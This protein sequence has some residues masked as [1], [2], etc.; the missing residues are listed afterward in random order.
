MG[1]LNK[2]KKKLCID[3][4]FLEKK[5][6]KKIS[7]F[8]KSLIKSDKY[9]FFLYLYLKFQSHFKSLMG[10]KFFKKYF[11]FFLIFKWNYF[12]KI[13]FFLCQ[14]IR[15]LKFKINNFVTILNFSFFFSS[16]LFFSKFWNQEFFMLKNKYFYNFKVLFDDFV[17]SKNKNFDDFLMDQFIFILKNF[18][19][20]EIKA[21]QVQNF[22][23]FYASKMF[24]LGL[25][26]LKFKNFLIEIINFFVK[27]RLI[28]GYGKYINKI[29]LKFIIKK[30][31]VNGKLFSK[32]ISDEIIYCKKENLIEKCNLNVKTVIYKNLFLKKE[33][34][35][36]LKRFLIRKNNILNEYRKN[37]KM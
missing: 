30:N 24:E 9:F 33:K 29:F 18:P 28:Y 22:F 20:T 25:N 12:H 21:F 37:I 36:M 6:K 2:I 19:L 5:K 8:S 23:I 34:S 7:Y 11:F 17:L 16:K 26:W 31:E 14:I 15:K 35:F 13:L 1:F 10:K 32:I 3:L 27:I 4:S